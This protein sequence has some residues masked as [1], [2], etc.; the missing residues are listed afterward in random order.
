MSPHPK[1]PLKQMQNAFQLQQILAKSNGRKGTQAGI[2]GFSTHCYKHAL[3]CAARPSSP[4]ASRA[5]SLL[6]SLDRNQ[7][8]VSDGK[9]VEWNISQTAQR[10]PPQEQLISAQISATATYSK[11]F[12]ANAL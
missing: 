8:N 11:H 9:N 2:Q 4:P 10:Q 12:R 1:T 7:R 5:G 6:G 3:R